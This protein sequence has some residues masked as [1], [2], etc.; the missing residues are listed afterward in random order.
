MEQQGFFVKT[1]DTSYQGPYL[2]LNEARDKAR[3]IG[4]DLEIYHGF[5]KKNTDGSWNN[6]NIYLVPKPLSI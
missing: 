5:L 1:E 3:S 2:S 6:K 4:P